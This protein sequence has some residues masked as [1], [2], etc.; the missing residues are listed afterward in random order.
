MFFGAG[1]GVTSIGGGFTS[2]L[3]LDFFPNQLSGHT[4]RHLQLT[5]MSQYGFTVMHSQ[6]AF[7][8]NNYPTREPF[9]DSF[10]NRGF[11]TQLGVLEASLGLPRAPPGWSPTL[12]SR[13]H[14]F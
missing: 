9:G 10:P 1:A 5:Y 4:F 11:V 8:D 14:D 3:A 6:Y 2:S 12:E 7:T 13:N